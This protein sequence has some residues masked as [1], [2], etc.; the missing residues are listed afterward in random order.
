MQ[1]NEINYT[2][3][4]ETRQGVEINQNSPEL[5]TN[6]IYTPAFLRENILLLFH[7]PSGYKIH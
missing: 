6:N 1:D 5:L 7:F 2:N 3:Q 4:R